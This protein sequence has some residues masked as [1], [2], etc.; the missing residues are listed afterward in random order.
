MQQLSRFFY[1]GALEENSAVMLDGDTAKHIWQVLRMDAGDKLVLTDGKGSSA[2]GTI[3]F[4][5]RH[6]CKVLVGKVTFHER[7]GKVL[8]LC[9]AFTKNNNR[10][11][12][13]LEKITELGVAS[14]VP[15][16][17]SRSEKT[18]IR[19]DRW[20][21]I[22][23]SAIL[24][25][26]QDYLPDLSEIMPIHEAIAKFAKVPKKFVAHCIPEDKK[27]PL[28]EML[29][30]LSDSVIM[31]GPEGDFSQNEVNLC[32][33]NGYKAASMGK[34]RLRTETAAV[35]AAAYFNMLNDEEG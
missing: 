29:K 24:Q 17:T 31:I 3:E 9:I 14:I 4:A 22:L 32:I 12:W 28:P 30:Q 13:L 19:E 18:H 27:K 26:Q 23:Q 35:A 1:N 20:H 15:L 8:H 33:E 25:S 2:E 10:N 16:I 7:K 21:K 5:E 6:K 34:Q 11:E